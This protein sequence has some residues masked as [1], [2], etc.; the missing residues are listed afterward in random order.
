MDLK[1]L[2]SLTQLF[3]IFE[4][5]LSMRKIAILAIFTLDNF[6]ASIY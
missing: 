4:A 5:I 3:R 2:M 1:I 6:S